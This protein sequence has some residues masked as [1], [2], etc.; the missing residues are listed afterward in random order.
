[1]TKLI[2]E[3]TYDEAERRGITERGWIRNRAKEMYKNPN[4]LFT[5]HENLKRNPEKNNLYLFRY[6]P[7]TRR[8]LP[9]YD[10]LPLTLVLEI[11]RNGLY[12]INFH[13]MLPIMRRQIL[14]L[15]MEANTEQKFNRIIRSK[16]IQTSVKFYLRNQIK[17]YLLEINKEEWD[18]IGELQIEQFRKELKTTVWNKTMGAL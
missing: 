16:E 7:K 2:F 1:M 11:K 6:E 13:Y 8:D 14:S 3:K 9:Y 5:I 12:G 4:Q 18:L 17:S 15:L 10:T